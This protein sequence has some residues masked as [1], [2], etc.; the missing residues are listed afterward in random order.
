MTNSYMYKI[1]IIFLPFC[2]VVSEFCCLIAGP[3]TDKFGPRKVL[4]ASAIVSALGYFCASLS[5]TL[6]QLILS[7]GLLVGIGASGAFVASQDAVAIWFD[8]MRSL[9]MGISG[10]GVAFG[11][12]FIVAIVNALLTNHGLKYALQVLALFELVSLLFAAF[13]TSRF[14]DSAVKNESSDTVPQSSFIIPEL[15]TTESAGSSFWFHRNN[16]AVSNH[17]VPKVEEGNVSDDVQ[18]VQSNQASVR[19]EVTTQSQQQSSLF[20]NKTYVY[21]LIA[22]GVITFGCSIP[23]FY[24]PLYGQLSGYSVVLSN[25]LV[26]VAAAASGIGRLLGGMIH[27]IF[28]IYITSCLSTLLNLTIIFLT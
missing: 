9:A 26:S 10:S 8:K 1:N 6:W 5:T 15:F 25:Y 11:S 27:I 3:L 22:F 2:V 19:V 17:M 7:Q 14:D 18:D 23:G 4:I 20:G 12:V 28:K 24:L 21:V 16:T 13:L